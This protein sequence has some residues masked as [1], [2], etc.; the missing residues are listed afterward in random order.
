MKVAMSRIVSGISRTLMDSVDLA[1]CIHELAP[2]K[3]TF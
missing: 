3:V 2:E 1:V